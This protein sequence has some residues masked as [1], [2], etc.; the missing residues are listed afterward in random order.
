MPWIASYLFL[1]VSSRPY[2]LFAKMKLLGGSA[3]VSAARVDKLKAWDT[4]A[5]Y[6]NPK[7]YPRYFSDMCDVS[8]LGVWKTTF[9]VTKFR[10]DDHALP[11]VLSNGNVEAG[12]QPS[13]PGENDE[14]MDGMVERTQRLEL[15]ELY[16]LNRERLRKVVE[17]N[18]ALSV[19]TLNGFV[20]C[21]KPGGSHDGPGGANFQ[22]G[23]TNSQGNYDGVQARPGSA[24]D[25]EDNA[26]GSGSLNRSEGT[27]SNN[28][29][30]DGD[31][32]GLVAVYPSSER[33]NGAV[34]LGKPFG[35]KRKSSK[36]VKRNKGGDGV[37]ETFMEGVERGI[38]Y[39]SVVQSMPSVEEFE[40]GGDS[41]A[42][43]VIDEDWRLE[44]G[45]KLISEFVDTSAQEKMYMSLWNQ[46]V[47]KEVYVYSDR[48]QL[49]VVCMFAQRYGA[50]VFALNLNVIFVRHLGELY[51]R[52]LIDVTGIHQATVELGRARAD[53]IAAPHHVDEQ[54]SHFAFHSRIMSEDQSAT[55]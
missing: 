14:H 11:L 50:V 48:R 2:L 46:Y 21:Y 36:R 18:R 37:M 54:L 34:G 16:A 39:S 9:F 20:S 1:P 3:G 47:L 52:G 17:G 38:L 15:A 5:V 25:D 45:D 22:A 53:A 23:P 26:S 30:F 29:S 40:A 42:E 4:E 43:H 31:E 32:N 12:A 8:G 28:V 7:R 41:D 51:R 44:V 33:P 55:K 35:S 49:D 24:H 27:G 6:V 10:A 13:H 19:E